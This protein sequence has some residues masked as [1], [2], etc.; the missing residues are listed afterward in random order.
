MSATGFPRPQMPPPTNEGEIVG[1]EW[2]AYRDRRGDKGVMPE[3]LGS[4]IPTAVKRVAKLEISAA[5]S[6]VVCQSELKA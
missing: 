5:I 3:R 6:E 4:S 1:A 2:I